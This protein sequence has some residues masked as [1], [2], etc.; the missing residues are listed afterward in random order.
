MGSSILF[1][2]A[3]RRLPIALVIVFACLAYSQPVY[4]QTSFTKTYQLGGGIEVA[5]C[6]KGPMSWGFTPVIQDTSLSGNVEITSVS[7]SES[8]NI[9]ATDPHGVA[10]M[11][12][13]VFIG[14]PSCGFPVGQLQ[15]SVNLGTYRPNRR[16]SDQ[17]QGSEES[18]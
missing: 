6:A 4:S 8:G 7:V 15:G 10:G 3:V 18:R 14:S 9:L 1:R 16:L 11:T 17:P 2:S 12:W 5:C 13:E